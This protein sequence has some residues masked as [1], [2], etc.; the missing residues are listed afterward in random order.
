MKY[1]Y[2]YAQRYNEKY[3]AK[4]VEYLERENIKYSF[5]EYNS[6]GRY[7]TGPL[8]YFSIWSTDKNAEQHMLALKE[9]EMREPTRYAHYSKADYAKAPFFKM[10]PKYP[11]I[12][13]RNSEDAFRY[14]CQWT[15]SVGAHVVRH[16]EQV[17]K[18]AIAKEPD[19]QR[20]TAFWREDTG[21]SITFASKPVV[22]LVTEHKLVGVSF[23]PVQVRRGNDSE[24]VFQMIS[25]NII[26][27]DCFVLDNAKVVDTCRICGK[28]QF[29][30]DHAD[31]PH[32]DF[33][34]VSVQS[35]LYMTEPIFG[36]GIAQP[37][38]IISQRFYQLLV[39]HKLSRN[40]V[41]TPV[42]DTSKQHTL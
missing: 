8:I 35:D 32:I 4:W 13:I 3:H 6:A 30:I 16:E 36:E 26:T 38:F 12:E 31:Q 18:I 23:C 2:Y 20:S 28:Q 14:S 1:E 5:S 25:P 22:D 7:T 29:Y 10:Y 19:I 11:R 40:V 33:S 42:V 27:Q 17:G 15:N 21:G 37:L 41:F 39:E 9:L 34:K 24:K